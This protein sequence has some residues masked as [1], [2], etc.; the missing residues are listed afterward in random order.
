M[1]RM[2]AKNGMTIVGAGLFIALIFPPHCARHSGN[3]HCRRDQFL[4]Y[5]PEKET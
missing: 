3:G 1:A 5:A 2:F 4:K